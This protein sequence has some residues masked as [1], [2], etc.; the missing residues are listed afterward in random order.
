MGCARRGGKKSKGRPTNP[1][2]RD[3]LG[4]P[5]KSGAVISVVTRKP[6]KPNSA[7]RTVVKVR[8]STGKMVYAYVP[9]EGHNLQ[10]HSKVLIRGGRRKDL[11]GMN[12]TVVRGAAGYDCNA[13][14]ARKNARSKYGTAR[15]ITK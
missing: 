10:P 15:A 11:I 1:R 12:L 9:G 13:V 3:L 7:N 8:L 6:K 2:S 5:Q 14:A 4:C